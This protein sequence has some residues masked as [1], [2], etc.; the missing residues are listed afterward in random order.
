MFTNKQRP[1]CQQAY[2]IFESLIVLALL[3][4]FALVGTAI[5]LH[6]KKA[7]ELPSDRTQELLEPSPD[8]LTEDSASS[9][10]E[11]ADEES[12]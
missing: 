1:N 11:T 7:A 2:T 6:E 8:H 9:V 4:I 12:R 3:V 5:Y 10:P